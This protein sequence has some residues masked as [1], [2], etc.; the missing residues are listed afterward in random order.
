MSDETK[1]GKALPAELAKKEPMRTPKGVVP[2]A[3]PKAVAAK[4][5]LGDGS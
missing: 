3:V 1:M 2:L 4:I 5:G